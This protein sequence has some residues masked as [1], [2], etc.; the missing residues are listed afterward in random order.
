MTTTY[1]LS[2][3]F[4]RQMKQRMLLTMIPTFTIA[5]V[6][7]ILVADRG[8]LSS[9]SLFL[10]PLFSVI[11]FFSVR[12]TIK[13]QQKRWS[14]YGLILRED[15]LSRIQDGFPG[16]IIDR[17][18]IAKITEYTGRE[19]LIQGSNKNLQIF[20]PATLESYTTL[21]EQL[22]QWHPIEIRPNN[23]RLNS[24]LILFAS[25][26]SVAAFAITA[27][28]PNK[29]IVIGVGTMYLILLGLAIIQTQKSSL[30]D[31]KTKSAIWWVIIPM[32]AI[33]LRIV[34]A[35]AGL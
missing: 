30:V 33:G 18:E 19:L 9:T 27:L 20:V 29:Y 4:F 21:K 2:P 3:E 24:L 17:S 31:R 28:S 34:A 6:I 10:I 12:N 26:G 15:A 13:E 1:R 11:L 22:E 32:L 5:M 8:K 35:I 7:G 23:D 14:S 16:V 25:F